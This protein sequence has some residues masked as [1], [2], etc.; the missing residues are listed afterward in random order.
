MRPE[1]DTDIAS[2]TLPWQSNLARWLPTRGEMHRPTPGGRAATAVAAF[3]EVKRGLGLNVRD[4]ARIVDLSHNTVQAWRKHEREP[5]PATV[6][7]L[8]EVKNLV[9]A[10]NAKGWTP[11]DWTKNAPGSD[12]SY[13]SI[14]E[15]EDGPEEV[16]RLT[17]WI[18]FE[19]RYRPSSLVED[20]YDEVDDATSYIPNAIAA[21][22][23]RR[24]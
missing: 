4:T 3:D 21:G 2:V 6:R 11:D 9:A 19:S 24:N 17:H 10:L 18:L 14:L 12:D 1:T 8:L 16:G 23:R 20:E 13:L 5:Y 7:R 15:R 22:N